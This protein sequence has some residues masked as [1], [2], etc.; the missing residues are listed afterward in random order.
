MNGMVTSQGSR[1][2]VVLV[3]SLQQADNLCGICDCCVTA[4]QSK[5]KAAQAHSSTKLDSSLAL[6]SVSCKVTLLCILQIQQ[7]YLH[8][9][10]AG[11][12]PLGF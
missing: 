10:S 12:L 7:G 1:R 11:T 2:Q 6:E 8:R 9:L 5:C 4:K 3:V